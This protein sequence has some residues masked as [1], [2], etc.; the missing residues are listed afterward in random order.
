MTAPV[1]TNEPKE[2]RAGITWE[3]T[4][5][6]IADYPAPTWTL[7]YW[8]KKTGSSGANFSITAAADGTGFDVTVLAAI[9]AALTAGDY[10]WVAIV[11]AGT[12]S[13]EVDRGTLV[14]LPRYDVASNFDDREHARIVLDAIESVIQGRATKDQQEYTIGGRSLK[15][16]PLDELEKFR[17]K[18]RAEV[19]ALD[20]AELARNGQSANQLVWKL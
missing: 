3:W 10:T 15:R 12:E 17:D 4:R 2:L 1:P 20:N 19:Y 16:T 11:T 5:E 13:R 6:D 8:F 18:Y 7:K 9:S 14:L